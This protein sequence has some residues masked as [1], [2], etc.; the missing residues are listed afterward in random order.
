[1]K[2]SLIFALAFIVYRVGADLPSAAKKRC[3]EYTSIFEN[4]TI[5]LQYAYCEDIG[6]G[7]GY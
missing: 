2:L 3:E 7:R 5:E 4:D 6:D 1:M